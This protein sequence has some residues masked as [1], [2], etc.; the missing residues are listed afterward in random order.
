MGD[1]LATPATL[2]AAPGGGWSWV[3]NPLCSRPALTPGKTGSRS[4]CPPVCPMGEMLPLRQLCRV[5]ARKE[6]D[7]VLKLLST[8]PPCAPE[9]AGLHS[10]NSPR[11]ALSSQ[12]PSQG[13]RGEDWRSGG[14]V[15]RQELRAGG[16]FAHQP[17][18]DEFPFVPSQWQGWRWEVWAGSG[19]K[20]PGQGQRSSKPLGWSWVCAL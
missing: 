2:L 18:Q 8:S 12:P 14:G 10:S 7:V 3:P 1:V 13:C 4:L 5:A 6:L 16:G 15:R 11:G 20:E 19:G 17:D 9:T